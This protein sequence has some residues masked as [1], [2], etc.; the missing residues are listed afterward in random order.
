MPS[1]IYSVNNT[2][3]MVRLASE[4]DDGDS[5][6]LREALREET[7]VEEEIL[8]DVFSVVPEDQVN[9]GTFRK[10]CVAL[11]D[12]GYRHQDLKRIIEVRF[13][14]EVNEN[15]EATDSYQLL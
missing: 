10:M 8:E 9:F 13:G 15:F 11:E 4:R 7:D 12:R 3:E 2:G 6:L 1:G 14:V 5:Q